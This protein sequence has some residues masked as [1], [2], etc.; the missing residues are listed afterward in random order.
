[1]EERIIR[2]KRRHEEVRYWL[3][4]ETPDGLG[5]RFE[6]DANGNVKTEKL[7]EV[8]LS[9]LER[10]RNGE[11]AVATPKLIKDEYY[12]TEPAVLQCPCGLLVE[13]EDPLDNVCECGRCYNASGWLVVPSW[14][15]DGEGEPH[16]FFID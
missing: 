6:C 8:G 14:E 16:S 7:S 4:F 9:N 2:P 12:W 1:M 5:Y 3:A 11:Y 13:L 10:C 15:C